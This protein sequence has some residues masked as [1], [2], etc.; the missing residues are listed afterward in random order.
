MGTISAADD[1]AVNAQR[2]LHDCMFGFFECVPDYEV[3]KALFDAAAGW[4]RN[5]G[6]KTLYGPFNLDYENGYGILVDGRDRPPV[7]LCGHTP[8]YYLD[9]VEQV[10]L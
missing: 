1:Q 4:A 9:F 5:R 7:L 8:P 3:A 2:G 6:L 10:R